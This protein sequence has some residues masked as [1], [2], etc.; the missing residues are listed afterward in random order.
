MNLLKTSKIIVALSLGHSI[1][2][3]QCIVPTLYSNDH[4]INRQY[5]AQIN[6]FFFQLTP[7]KKSLT[8]YYL[9]PLQCNEY[10]NIYALKYP[11]GFLYAY[12]MHV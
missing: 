2:I 8:Y 6:I 12:T 3:K 7:L 10:N 9:S 5:K 1:E 4:I 11:F